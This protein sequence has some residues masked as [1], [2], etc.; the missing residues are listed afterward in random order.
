MI[1]PALFVSHGSP[2]LAIQDGPAHRFL[3]EYGAR[4]GKPAAILSVSAHWERTAPAVSTA[5]QPE[6][7]HD[8]G[9]FPQA[10]FDI[11]YPAPGAPEI[12]AQARALLRAAGIEAAADPARGLDHGTWVPLHLMYPD[13]D[14]PVFQL[15]VQTRMGPAHHLALGR[16]LRP[17]R[18]AGVMILGSGSLTHNLRAFFTQDTTGP[19]P[20]GAPDWAPGWVTGFV[21]WIERALA[22]GRV[23]DLL[24]YRALAPHAAE[25]HPTEEH[26]L[27]LF[28]ALGASLG[29][30]LGATLGAGATGT[31]RRVHHSIDRAVLAMDV[32]EFA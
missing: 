30:S 11:R 24:A 15:S 25:N 23:D 12:A 21:D 26:F 18:D 32:Y 4:L 10:L 14:V 5:G 7:I 8:F 17:L 28:A 29:A 20:G 2:M 27:P 16:A 3:K 22:E 13:A 1:F 6:T 9:G 19:A 31:G